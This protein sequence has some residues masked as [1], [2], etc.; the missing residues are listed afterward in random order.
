LYH[1]D[2][3]R[4]RLAVFILFYKHVCEWSFFF[5]FRF[6]LKSWIYYSLNYLMNL[7]KTHL[8]MSKWFKISSNFFPISVDFRFM[9]FYFITEF[10]VIVCTKLYS[11]NNYHLNSLLIHWISVWKLQFIF[12]EDSGARH[13]KLYGICS[14]VVFKKCFW[15]YCTLADLLYL[16]YLCVEAS[17]S[18]NPRK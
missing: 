7:V 9:F 15:L 6:D 13:T 2:L 1:R 4:C 12:N 16:F 14:V 11:L 8:T 3:I 5:F 10:H 17:E 18:S